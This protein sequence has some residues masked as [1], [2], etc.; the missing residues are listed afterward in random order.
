[1]MD[2]LDGNAIAGLLNDVFGVEMTTA[3]CACASCGADGQVA[4]LLVYSRAPG[5]VA[6]CRYCTSVVM[7]LVTVRAVTCVDLRGLSMLE[8]AT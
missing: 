2:A 1:M 6:R 8:P 4:E 3:A 7:V 5:T